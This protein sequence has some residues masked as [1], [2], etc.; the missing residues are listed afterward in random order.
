MV[1]PRERERCV[2]GGGCSVHAHRYGFEL[3]DR[4]SAYAERWESPGN[5]PGY[6]IRT[7]LGIR[8]RS[9]GQYTRLLPPAQASRCP[10]QD[11]TLN[12]KIYKAGDRTKKNVM[13]PSSPTPNT[14]THTWLHATSTP[15]PNAEEHRAVGRAGVYPLARART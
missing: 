11:G 1:Q 13:L 10:L 5:P 7:L 2:S 4:S 9:Q 8:A 14:H 3:W 6:R 15:K 12:E